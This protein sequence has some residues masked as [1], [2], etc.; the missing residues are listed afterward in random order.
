[1]TPDEITDRTLVII[2][3]LS[4]LKEDV[5]HEAVSSDDGNTPHFNGGVLSAALTILEATL[6]EDDPRLVIEA[7]RQC[8]QRLGRALATDGTS[9]PRAESSRLERVPHVC[10]ERLR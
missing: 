10:N 5:L 3:L 2:R 8:E 4:D 6:D 1:M 7:R 9:S